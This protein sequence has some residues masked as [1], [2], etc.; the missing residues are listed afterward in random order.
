MRASGATSEL[1]SVR[2]SQFMMYGAIR[3]KLSFLPGELQ[4][5]EEHGVLVIQ[6]QGQ[7][8]LQ[9]RSKRTALSKFNELRRSMELQF[10]TKEVTSEEKAELLKGILNEALLADVGRRP[11]RKHSSAGST[12]LWW[13]EGNCDSDPFTPCSGAEVRRR[14]QNPLR[15]L[16][17]LAIEL[18]RPAILGDSA[19]NALGSSRRKLSF[20]LNCDLYLSVQQ[21]S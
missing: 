8:I 17:T 3:V 4:L 20:D 5:S 14:N 16:E 12:H 2:N 6:V 18:Q 7:E 19:N 9:T 15:F 10:P 11:P 21:A 13:V 1:V